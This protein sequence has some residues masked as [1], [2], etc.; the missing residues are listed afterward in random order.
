M[1]AIHTNQS[2][3]EYKVVDTQGMDIEYRDTPLTNC[4]VEEILV[5]ISKNLEA[6]LPPDFGFFPTAEVSITAILLTSSVL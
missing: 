2:M 6:A 4:W 3:F 1:I 5:R